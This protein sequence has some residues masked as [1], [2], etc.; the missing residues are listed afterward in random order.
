MKAERGTTGAKGFNRREHKRRKDSEG[1]GKIELEQKATPTRR[2]Q[3][4]QT[5]MFFSSSAK[6]WLPWLPSVKNSFL[7]SPRFSASLCASALN[8]FPDRIQFVI[9]REISVQASGFLMR[10]LSLLAAGFFVFR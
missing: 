10:V 4:E 6:S 8:L 1:K 5:E 7:S 9:I 3:A 2:E